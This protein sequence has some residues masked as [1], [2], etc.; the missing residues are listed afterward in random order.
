MPKHGLL[1]SQFPFTQAIVS[2][3][4]TLLKP[5]SHFIL[6]WNGDLWRQDLQ[7]HLAGSFYSH[8]CRSVPRQDFGWF[9]LSPPQLLPTTPLLS[10]GACGLKGRKEG[11][12][13]R[14]ET[15]GREEVGVGG[16]IPIRASGQQQQLCDLKTSKLRCDIHVDAGKSQ[17][18]VI[19]RSLCEQAYLV[20]ERIFPVMENHLCI[21]NPT[22]AKTTPTIQFWGNKSKSR[23][24][25]QEWFKR[26]PFGRL[27]RKRKFSLTKKKTCP[28]YSHRWIIGSSVL[29]N[30]QTL[31]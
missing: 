21:S 12:R 18:N 7:S 26:S 8:T 3:T 9:S 23:N 28:K 2:K 15:K 16:R 27:V 14:K 29:Y 30:D 6:L 19:L 17:T 22:P 4:A 31:A 24:E 20:K 13:G 11:E 10:R 1:G 5:R 25:K